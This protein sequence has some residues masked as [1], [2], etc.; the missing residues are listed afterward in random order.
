[1]GEAQFI[2]VGQKA[3]LR[4][5]GKGRIEGGGKEKKEKKR[6]RGR[7]SRNLILILLLST[8]QCSYPQYIDKRTY[9]S[10]RVRLSP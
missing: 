5:K 6:S 9:M 3:R 8:Y 4:K 2:E 10:N 1:M 7:S